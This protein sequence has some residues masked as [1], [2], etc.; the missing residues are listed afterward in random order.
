MAILNPPSSIIDYSTGALSSSPV[1]GIFHNDDEAIFPDR[2]SQRQR[3]HF[4]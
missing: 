2:L 1:D 3:R 4:L